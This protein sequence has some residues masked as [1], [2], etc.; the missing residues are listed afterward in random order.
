MSNSVRRWGL[1]FELDPNLGLSLDLLPHRPL[2]IFVLAVS[3]DRNNSGPSLKVEKY[4]KHISPSVR[5]VL[6]KRGMGV[7]LIE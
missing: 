7:A 6:R 3:L 1:P 2:S 4:K 5:R